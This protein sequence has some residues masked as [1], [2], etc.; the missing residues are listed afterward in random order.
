M[1]THKDSVAARPRPPGLPPVRLLLASGSP[2]R[3]ELLADLGADFAIVPS[4]IDDGDMAPPPGATAA[5]WTVAMAYLKARAAVDALEPHQS[6]IVMGADTA[7]ELDGRIIGKPDCQDRARQTLRSMVGQ[8]QRVVT[9]IALLDP[10]RPQTHR[11][12]LADTALVT[13]GTIYEDTIDRYLISD[14]W[15]GKA[16]GYNLTERLADG[17]PITVQ[18]DPDTVVGLPTSKLSEWLAATSAWS[19]PA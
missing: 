3:R 2:R 13:F 4:N 17:W 5:A 15:R 6:G 8:T 10:S 9:G 14:A 18:G 19:A 16:G 7:C 11:L 12:L 1:S